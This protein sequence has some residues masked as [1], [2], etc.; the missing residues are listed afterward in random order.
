MIS[1]PSTHLYRIACYCCIGSGCNGLVFSCRARC[2]WKFLEFA[3]GGR[4]SICNLCISGSMASFTM[5]RSTAES[6][7]AL[8]CYRVVQVWACACWHPFR[9]CSPRSCK[10][11]ATKRPLW[12]T[13]PGSS[14]RF[15]PCREHATS[16]GHPVP[17]WAFKSPS[18]SQGSEVGRVS[19]RSSTACYSGVGCAGGR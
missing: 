6:M 16:D 14:F 9:I 8:P 3:Q 7:T 18:R 4:S 2:A 13:P 11:F 19:V 10:V 15:S 12:H 5:S 17:K 1:D